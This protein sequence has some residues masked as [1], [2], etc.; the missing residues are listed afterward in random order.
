[1][2]A[3]KDLIAEGAK[4]QAKNQEGKTARDL[5]IDG[6]K[7]DSTLRVFDVSMIE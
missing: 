5:I 2:A 6:E 3:I 7:K 1:M 4:I